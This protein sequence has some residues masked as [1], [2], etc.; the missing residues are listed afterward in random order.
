MPNQNYEQLFRPY[1]D[2]LHVNTRLRSNGDAYQ[3]PYS[4]QNQKT[5]EPNP[6]LSAFNNLHLE[7][8][9]L[10]HLLLNVGKYL[11]EEDIRKV[12]HSNMESIID[13]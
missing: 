11:G 9:E 10:D 12:N 3:R 13:G 7:N 1:V 4:S 6:Y 8:A 5:G 2:N